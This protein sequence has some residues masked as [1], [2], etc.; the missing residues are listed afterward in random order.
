MGFVEV[1]QESPGTT[2]AR[3]PRGSPLVHGRGLRPCPVLRAGLGS[4]GAADSLDASWVRGEVT[5]GG[6]P[7]VGLAPH[8]T[9]PPLW[10]V[11]QACTG[12]HAR[13]STVK[14]RGMAGLQLSLGADPGHQ[15]LSPA[16]FCWPG[17]PSCSLALLGPCLSRGRRGEAVS[18]RGTQQ[19]PGYQLMSGAGRPPRPLGQPLLDAFCLQSLS[20]QG[21]RS[22]RAWNSDVSVVATTGRVWGPPPSWR[23]GRG[24]GGG[25]GSGRGRCR[26]GLAPW[27]LPAPAPLRVLASPPLFSGISWTP[28]SLPR[29]APRTL[30]PSPESLWER[31]RLPLPAAAPRPVTQQ[32]GHH[33]QADA[34]CRPPGTGRT[35]L[36]PRALASTPV[37]PQPVVPPS[38]PPWGACGPSTAQHGRDLGIGP[39]GLVSSIFKRE[40]MKDSQ[41]ALFTSGG[42]GRV[43]TPAERAPHTGPGKLARAPSPPAGTSFRRPGWALPACLPPKELLPRR[44][45]P[46]E[47][48]PQRVGGAPP[49]APD[50]VHCTP[51]HAVPDL[52]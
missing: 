44:A 8:A 30:S 35:C 33:G 29:T 21:P 22:T 36:A 51:L 2:E 48:L 50:R 49:G 17:A 43:A 1:G 13:L 18:G 5:E 12:P 38:P 26:K 37:E 20:C 19:R 10:P 39:R 25:R 16:P 6:C 11:P 14:P 45:S 3:W 15:S 46:Q 23:A 40:P 32:L 9:Y 7:R 4:A 24:R 42:G 27:G 31:L 47:T 34:P 52:L 41:A 28:R